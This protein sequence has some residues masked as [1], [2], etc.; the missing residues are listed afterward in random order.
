LAY[1]PAR[2]RSL[3]ALAPG[4]DGHAVLTIEMEGMTLVSDVRQT[5]VPE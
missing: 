2:S 4:G 1:P 5:G 3:N